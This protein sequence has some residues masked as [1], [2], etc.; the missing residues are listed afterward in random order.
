VV[1][2]ART[3]KSDAVP[4]S[5]STRPCRRAVLQDGIYLRYNL[6]SPGGARLTT[7]STTK[8][9]NRGRPDD[10]NCHFRGTYHSLCAQSVNAR[11]RSVASR[12]AEHI[13]AAR[14]LRQG[15]GEIAVSTGRKS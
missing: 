12:S 7:R 15:S 2:A 5:F 8:H 9:Q 14:K 6:G 11:R 13:T 10:G 1:G 3:I 4:K